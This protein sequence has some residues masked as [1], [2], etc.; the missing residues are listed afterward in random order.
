MANGKFTAKHSSILRILTKWSEYLEEI[1]DNPEKMV[2]KRAY[3]LKTVDNQLVLLK[4]TED[5]NPK[6]IRRLK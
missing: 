2:L 3:P 6:L 4:N 1:F 5:G